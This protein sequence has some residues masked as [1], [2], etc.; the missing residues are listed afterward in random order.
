LHLL[1]IGYDAKIP[2]LSQGWA[3]DRAEFV[4]LVC[5]VYRVWSKDEDEGDADGQSDEEQRDPHPRSWLM[6]LCRVSGGR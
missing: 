6:P 3:G 5:A 1:E 4:R 2:T